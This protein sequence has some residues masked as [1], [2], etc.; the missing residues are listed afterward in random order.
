MGKMQCVL[1]LVM[2][3]S[4]WPHGLQPVGLLS[5]W[6]FSRI[7]EW[8]AMPS[9][10]VSSQPRDWTQVSCI[11]GRFLTWWTIRE[12][13]VF[14]NKKFEMY[15]AG[16]STRIQG[17]KPVIAHALSPQVIEQVTSFLQILVFPFILEMMVWCKICKIY[18]ACLIV[19][20]FAASW[21]ETKNS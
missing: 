20:S 11:A 10:R 18:N 19:F 13:H 12:A 9:F 2:S 6:G 5:P 3:D 7:L 8:V 1:C 21:T 15:A 4:L 14:C 17:R 16:C